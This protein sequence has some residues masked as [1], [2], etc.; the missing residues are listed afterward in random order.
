MQYGF[1]AAIAKVGLFKF[2]SDLFW[3]GMF[4][5]LYNQVCW[6]NKKPEVFDSW[7]MLIDII[8]FLLTSCTSL[9]GA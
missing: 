5:H 3:I 6:G 1:K 7:N 4:Y 9:F 2:L 8:E